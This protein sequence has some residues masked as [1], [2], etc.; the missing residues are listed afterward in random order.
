MF[1][2]WRASELI[3]RNLGRCQIQDRSSVKLSPLPPQA[4]F[5][6]C[7]FRREAAAAAAPLPLKEPLRFLPS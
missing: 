7:H 6:K 3:P 1:G 2:C 4:R 5:L